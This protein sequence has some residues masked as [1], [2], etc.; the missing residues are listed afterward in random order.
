MNVQELVT[1]VEEL[2]FK[3]SMFG[4]D[5]D[6][7]DIQLDKI[8][9][10]IEALVK[11]KDEEIASLRKGIGAAAAPAAET[12]QEPVEEAEAETVEEP[13][14]EEPD[15]EFVEEAAEEEEEEEPEDNEL[16]SRIAELEA[17]LQAA[18]E[19][20]DRAQQ[21]LAEYMAT[22]EQAEQKVA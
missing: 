8:C 18:N 11:E 15:E 4:Y 14:V 19:R 9:D 6:E 12:A 2:A 22:V 20:A 16:L 5:K 3:T 21:Q 7:V 1:Y 10:E 17:Q 13:I